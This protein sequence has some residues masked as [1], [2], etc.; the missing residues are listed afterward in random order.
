MKWNR[1][2]S[3]GISDGKCHAGS[4]PADADNKEKEMT[5]RMV[6]V[7]ERNWPDGYEKP[8]VKKVIGP[9][10]FH[11]WGCSFVEFEAGPGNY[12]VAIVE[13]GDGTVRMIDPIDIVFVK[14]E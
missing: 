5:N 13:M 11:C 6:I 1:I 4:K 7:H 2:H 8:P 14:G 10:V 9:G 12:T 3:H